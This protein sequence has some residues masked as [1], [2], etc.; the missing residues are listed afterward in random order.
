MGFFTVS[1]CE[2]TNLTVAT[3]ERDG[4]WMP[5]ARQN[6]FL[7]HESE[8]REGKI[9]EY[10]TCLWVAFAPSKTPSPEPPAADC[11]WSISTRFWTEKMS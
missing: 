6:F 5:T 10:F 4:V 3:L 1:L 7:L 9:Y 11:S 8:G 2:Q